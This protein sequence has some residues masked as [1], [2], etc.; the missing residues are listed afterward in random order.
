MNWLRWISCL[1]LFGFPVVPVP[2]LSEPCRL[3]FKKSGG[4]RQSLCRPSAGVLVQDDAWP[5]LTGN[6]LHLK[7]T[8]VYSTSPQ[9]NIVSGMESGLT[10][11]AKVPK[12]IL[13]SHHNLVFK[14]HGPHFSNRILIS[15]CLGICAPLVFPVIPWSASKYNHNLRLD[16]TSRTHVE[17][18]YFLHPTAA[19]VG[20]KK[21]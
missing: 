16:I 18:S 1:Q 13:D 9:K 20:Y 17:N 10:Y 11:V 7:G 15:W 2:G 21:P 5:K 3:S 14:K 4:L 12:N 8:K 6:T 19:Q